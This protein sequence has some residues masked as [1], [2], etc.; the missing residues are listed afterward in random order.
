MLDLLVWL[1]C[2]MEEGLTW[3]GGWELAVSGRGWG[4]SCVEG[5]GGREKGARVWVGVVLSR[6]GSAR[7]FVRRDSD[8]VFEGVGSG[9]WA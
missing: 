2:G 9:A 1:R 8:E 3:E 4:G 6:L 7:Y 5:E